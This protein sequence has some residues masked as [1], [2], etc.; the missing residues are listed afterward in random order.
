MIF[1]GMILMM[2]VYFRIKNNGDL[3]KT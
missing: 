2:V 1:I 3:L